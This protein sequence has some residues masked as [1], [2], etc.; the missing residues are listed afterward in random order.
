[1]EEK[2]FKRGD[3]VM[4]DKGELVQF[5]EYHS[6]NPVFV[7]VTKSMKENP[8]GDGPIIF[9]EGKDISA[10]SEEEW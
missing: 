2:R 9:M 6:N 10:L 5:L 3:K 8:L 7:Y 4:T 1:M